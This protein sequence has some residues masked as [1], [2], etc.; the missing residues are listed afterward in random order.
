MQVLR[1]LVTRKVLTADE[2]Q[3]AT[4][5]YTASGSTR[6]LHEFLIERGVAKEEPILTAMSEEFGMELVDLTKTA[7]DPETIKSVPLKLVHRHTLLPLARENGTLK[8]ATGDPY[9]VNALDEL[10]MLTGLQIHP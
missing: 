1:W 6:P 7:V 9:N 2:L 10:Q 4:E 3:R 8:V 5:A